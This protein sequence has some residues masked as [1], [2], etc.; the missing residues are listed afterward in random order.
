MTEAPSLAKA[1]SF[2]DKPHSCNFD[3]IVFVIESASV[4]VCSLNSRNSTAGVNASP[5]RYWMYKIKFDCIATS[6]DSS[7]MSAIKGDFFN[8]SFMS[9]LNTELKERSISLAELSFE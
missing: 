9:R 2:S 7:V 3:I 8:R 1:I 4:A 5:R 6:V